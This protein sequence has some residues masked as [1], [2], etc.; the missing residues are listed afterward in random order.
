MTRKR[1]LLVCLFLPLG[2]VL[3]VLIVTGFVRFVQEPGREI[4]TRG[5]AVLRNADRVET[6]RLDD[7]GYGDNVKVATSGD[8]IADYPIKMQGKTLGP[9]FAANLARAVLD[10]RTFI[11]PNDNTCEINPGVAFRAWRGQECVEV[12]LCFHCQQMLVTT[13]NAQG[14]ETHS[15]Y[16]ELAFTREKFL[17]LAQEAFPADKE[18]QSLR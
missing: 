2:S 16:P 13:R 3:T 17:A 12:I 10:P 14:K 1:K 18:I 11:G 5:T 8:V 6:F 15:A 9:D 7:G 4:G